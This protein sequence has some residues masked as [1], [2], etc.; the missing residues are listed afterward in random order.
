MS[1]AESIN[2]KWNASLYDSKH[3]FVFK[4]GEDLLELLQPKPGERIMDLGC[5]TGYLAKQIADAGA[6][7]TGI[8]N[9]ADMIAKAKAAYPELDFRVESATDFYSAEGYDAIFSNAV[10]HWIKEKEKAIDCMYLNLKDNG[11]LV[12]EMGGKANV[13]AIIVALRTSL[14]DYGFQKQAAVEQWYFPSLSAYASLLEKRGFRVTYAAHFD[15]ETELKNTAHGIKDWIKMFGESFLKG[16]DEP[17]L[18]II[19]TEVE[20]KLRPTHFRNGKWYADYKRLRIVAMKQA[21]WA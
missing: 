18:D 20:N 14:V 16:I 1:S 13:E 11:R 12:L 5:G 3:D 21:G 8:D 19:L 7:V 6:V 9:S 17:V 15:R 4:Y 2:I 10:L